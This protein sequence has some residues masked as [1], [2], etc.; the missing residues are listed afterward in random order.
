MLVLSRKL[1]ED[2]CIGDDVRVRVVEV[3]GDRV[4]LGVLAPRSVPVHRSEV[5]GRVHDEAQLTV[6]HVAELPKVPFDDQSA[7]VMRPLLGVPFDA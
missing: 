4:R 3:R 7:D 5:I 6:G 1:N 2:I